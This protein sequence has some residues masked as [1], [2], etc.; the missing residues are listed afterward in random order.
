MFVKFIDESGLNGKLASLQWLGPATFMWCSA[1]LKMPTDQFLDSSW[2]AEIGRR[3]LDG[4]MPSYRRDSR[5]S[6][7]LWSPHSLILS[8]IGG[9]QESTQYLNTAL[10]L[11]QEQDSGLNAEYLSPFCDTSLD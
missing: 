2:C 5:T 7:V 11:S 8:L 9:F 3:A 6:Q 4:G 1:V 10:F